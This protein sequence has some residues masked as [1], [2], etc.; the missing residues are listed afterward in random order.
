[1]VNVSTPV[2]HIP[3]LCVQWKTPED[4]QRKCPKRVEFHSKNKFEKLMH[5]VGF[6][7]RNLTRCTVTW[8]SDVSRS[9]STNYFLSGDLY[10]NG[11]LRSVG[12]MV[13]GNRRFGLTYRSL[14]RGSSSR[15]KGRRLKS[16]RLLP[17]LHRSEKTRDVGLLRTRTI[18]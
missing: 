8:T 4:G 16:L 18:W 6:I 9:V 10:S 15:N 3:L 1:M 11:R 14:L 12:W 17:V 5:L 7:I 2:W 13:V